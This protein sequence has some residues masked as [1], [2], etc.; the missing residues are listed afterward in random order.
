MPDVERWRVAAPAKLNLWLRVAGR[1]PDGFHELESLLVLLDLADAVSVGAD[2]PDLV[3]RGPSAAGVPVDRT[4]L[5]WRGWVAG[6]DAEAAPGGVVVEKRIP[7]AAGLG[8]GSSDAAAAWRLAR[9]AAGASAEPPTSRRW[10]TCRA[11]VPTSRSSP[12]APA[13]AFVTGIGERV[14]PVAESPDEVEVVL[15]HPPFGLSTAAVFAELRRADWSEPSGA[16][17][18]DPGSNDLLAPAR[19]LRPE[20]DDVFR[21]VAG[22]GGGPQLDRIGANRVRDDR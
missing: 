6:W 3:V 21:I 16:R 5:A 9:H 2:E 12:P 17:L 13:T 14:E 8:G 22:A 15:V 1:R 20:L 19:R 7:V 11:S 10:T 18:M 4:N